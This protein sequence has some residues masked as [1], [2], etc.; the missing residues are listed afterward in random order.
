[1]ESGE[2]CRSTGT[3]CSA[4]FLII[5]CFYI[6]INLSFKL[7]KVACNSNMSSQDYSN[8][9]PHSLLQIEPYLKKKKIGASII[10]N[11]MNRFLLRRGKS[12]LWE[13]DIYDLAYGEHSLQCW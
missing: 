5:K 12:L 2:F 1:M 10:K 4:I 11:R 8:S 3:N 13:G 6:R 7:V 9:F